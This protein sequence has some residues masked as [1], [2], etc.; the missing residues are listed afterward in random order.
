MPPLT[1]AQAAPDDGEEEANVAP[2]TTDVSLTPEAVRN[3]PEFRAL[4]RELRQEVRRRGQ[5]ERDMARDRETRAAAEAATLAQQEQQIRDRLGED[6]LAVWNELAELSAS[7]PV[8]AA[9]RLAEL[10]AQTQQ[11]QANLTTPTP[12]ANPDEEGEPV[13]T[14]TGAGTPPPM[15]SGVAATAP[16]APTEGTSGWDT[17]IESSQREFDEI[18]ERNQNPLTRNRVT[19][20]DRGRGMMAYL[21]GSYAKAFKERG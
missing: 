1:T 7:N 3:S 19:M 17:I 2:S 12:P 13:T 4:Q 6:G 16:L 11:P 18:V 8:A 14:P 10:M 15:P 5:L 9:D 21:L 20:R